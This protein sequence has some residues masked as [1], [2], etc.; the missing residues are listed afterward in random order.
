MKIAVLIYQFL[1]RIKIHTCIIGSHSLHLE[2]WL[3]TRKF[4]ILYN[5]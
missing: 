5:L 1:S 2:I 3:F 4:G